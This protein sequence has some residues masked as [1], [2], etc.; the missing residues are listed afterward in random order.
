MHA[1]RRRRDRDRGTE[2]TE[3]AG[4]GETDSVR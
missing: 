2:L 3:Q 4:G 1:L